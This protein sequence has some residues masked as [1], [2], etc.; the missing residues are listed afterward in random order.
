[1]PALTQGVDQLTSGAAQLAD[2][3][4]QFQQQVASGTVDFSQ[5]SQLQQGAQQ[6]AAGTAGVS[7]GLGHGELDP[8][9]LCRRVSRT[10]PT[11]SLPAGTLTQVEQGFVTGCTPALTSSLTSALTKA[12]TSQLGATAAAQTAATVAADVAPG[13]CFRPVHQRVPDL[14]PRIRHRCEGRSAGVGTQ[15][16]SAKD[17]DTGLTLPRPRRA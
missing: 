13:S 15:A 14:R 2:G 11:T 10:I 1:M 12:L 8:P 5:L 9:G 7:C 3:I 16:L 17:P 4:A 6:V